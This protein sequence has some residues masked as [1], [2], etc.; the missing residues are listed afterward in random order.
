MAPS[1]AMSTRLAALTDHLTPLR[2]KRIGAD[3][4]PRNLPTRPDSAAIGPPAR[5]ARDRGDRV[6]LLGAGPLVG[7]DADR[8]V[9]L[10]HRLRREPEDDEPEAVERDRAV[11]PALDLERHRERARPLGRLDRHLSG[12]AR[13]RRSRSCTFRSTAR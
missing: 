7:D 11:A 5:A 3:S 9:A 2:S 13:D 6:A 1:A 12:E 8:P 4:T 10:A